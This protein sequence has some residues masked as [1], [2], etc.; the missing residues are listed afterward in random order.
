MQK[1]IVLK[2]MKSHKIFKMAAQMATVLKSSNSH[3]FGIMTDF[4]QICIKIHG[5]WSYLLWNIF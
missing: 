4:D 5:L 2:F 3:S 1:L